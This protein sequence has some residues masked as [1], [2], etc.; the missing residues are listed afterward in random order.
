MHY[1]NK[2]PDLT[3]GIYSIS[4]LSPSISSIEKEIFDSPPGF[5]SGVLVWTLH[6]NHLIESV[7]PRKM[8][9]SIGTHNSDPESSYISSIQSH[10][11]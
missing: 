2:L 4:S 7:W 9:P 8:H 6:N 3:R 5:K 11:N 10:W 1:P